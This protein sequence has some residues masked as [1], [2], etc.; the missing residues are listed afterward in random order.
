MN[1]SLYLSLSSYNY[2]NNLAHQ[3]MGFLNIHVRLFSFFRRLKMNKFIGGSLDETDFKVENFEHEIFVLSNIETLQQEK[4]L[5]IKI[6]TNGLT[7]TFWVVE[8]L[9]ESIKAQRIT[10]YLGDATV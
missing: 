4:Y 1:R 6:H 2:L 9:D 5:K 10:A 8:G 3:T 7:Y